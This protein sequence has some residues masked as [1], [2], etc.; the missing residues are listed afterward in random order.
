MSTTTITTAPASEEWTAV[1]G[2]K[3]EKRV[4][5][6]RPAFEWPD[7]VV[8]CQL[9]AQRDKNHGVLKHTFTPIISVEDDVI[10]VMLILEANESDAIGAGLVFGD[11]QITATGFGPRTLMRFTLDLTIDTSA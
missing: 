2:D 8:I 4:G 10:W 5:F 9:R 3:W 1:R 11:I 6:Q 7:P